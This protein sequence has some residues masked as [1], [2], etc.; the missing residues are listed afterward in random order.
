MS[1]PQP[2]DPFG[3]ALTE[4]ERL[5]LVW[6]NLTTAG[7][8]V[9]AIARLI[10][11]SV[12]NLT[13]DRMW[14]K[15]TVF[16]QRFS[17]LVE[18]YKELKSREIE[19]T[20]LITIMAEGFKRMERSHSLWHND[21]TPKSA[22]HLLESVDHWTALSTLLRDVYPIRTLRGWI[23]SINGIISLD[24][25]AL[26][27]LPVQSNVSPDSLRLL[28]IG[29]KLLLQTLPHPHRAKISQVIDSQIGALTAFGDNRPGLNYEHGLASHAVLE[30]NDSQID[31]EP[32]TRNEVTA[33]NSDQVNVRLVISHMHVR[34][35]G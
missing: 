4:I 1:E 15:V 26:V 32:H 6:N 27:A 3:T 7:V 22:L 8:S 18:L 12:S 30:F 19:G 2:D 33:M 5:L 21:K 9:S 29:A 31:L 20:S 14:I 11:Q 35:R 16:F 13:L 34:S 25:S 10:H 28:E 17:R 24:V 23:S